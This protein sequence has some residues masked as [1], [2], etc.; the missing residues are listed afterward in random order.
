ML[1]RLLVVQRRLEVLL[2]PPRHAAHDHEA[3]EDE[4]G[5]DRAHDPHHRALLGAGKP[6]GVLAVV[7]AARLRPL[8]RRP[9]RLQR[10][11]QRE[12]GREGRR[13]VEVLLRRVDV[14]AHQDLENFKI[15]TESLRMSS[16]N[17]RG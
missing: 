5:D 12:L 7:D 8:R 6:F 10:H 1:A 15:L 4:D 13:G 11:L 17:I 16:L 9:R 14:R 2:P 3:E